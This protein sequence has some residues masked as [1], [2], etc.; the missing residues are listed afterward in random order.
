MVSYNVYKQSLQSS[1]S[2]KSSLFVPTQKLGKL[3]SQNFLLRDFNKFANNFSSVK[4][5]CQ[6]GRD[7]KCFGRIPLSL[8]LD[9]GN[10]P[11]LLTFCQ[12]SNLFM[13]NSEIYTIMVSTKHFSSPTN[14]NFRCTSTTPTG[15]RR[16]H[17]MTQ[18]A[19]RPQI[20]HL[21]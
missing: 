21:K 17:F 1:Q 15:P 14:K 16:P 12:D 6:N 18:K 4:F 11:S 8:L 13:V 3:G 7:K 9:W 19:L 20:F 2:L 10:L 5:L